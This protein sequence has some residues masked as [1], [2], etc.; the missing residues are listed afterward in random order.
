MNEP[1]GR[2]RKLDGQKKK[3]NDANNKRNKRHQQTT[4]EKCTFLQNLQLKPTELCYLMRTVVNARGKKDEKET[5]R[6]RDVDRK[7]DY[8]QL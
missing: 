1:S 7:T 4:G 6:E 8:S 3:I 2:A 5:K